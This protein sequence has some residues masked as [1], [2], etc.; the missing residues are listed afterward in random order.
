MR[1]NFKKE[2]SYLVEACSVLKKVV[3]NSNDNQI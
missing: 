2:M 1:E 3:N